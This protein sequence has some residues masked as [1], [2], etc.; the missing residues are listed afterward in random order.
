M[1]IPSPAALAQMGGGGGSPQGGQSMVPKEPTFKANFD[2]PVQIIEALVKFLSGRGGM[3]VG[4]PPGDPQS[5][6]GVGGG[7][8]PQ[9][10][11]MMRGM[12][13]S[14]P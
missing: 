5:P 12:N 10:D 6:G 13:P 9:S 4:M 7:P 8:G 3:S 1:M 2:I 14:L 11:P